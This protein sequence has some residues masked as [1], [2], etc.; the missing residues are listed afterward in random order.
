MMRWN[1]TRWRSREDY[2]D[3]HPGTARLIR[4]LPRPAHRHL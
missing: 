3:A 4:G 2:C 1:K